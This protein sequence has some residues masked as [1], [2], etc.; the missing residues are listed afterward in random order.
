VEAATQNLRLLEFNL[1]TFLLANALLKMKMKTCP[2]QFWSVWHL[3]SFDQW[4]TKMEIAVVK[5]KKSLLP[6]ENVCQ[7]RISQAST[8][9]TPGLTAVVMQTMMVMMKR[10]ASVLA[11]MN[12][13]ATATYVMTLTTQFVQRMTSVAVLPAMK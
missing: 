12:I 6:L 13:Q 3:E 9:S 10:R 11:A 8:T 2:A 4:I 5:V 7:M 1:S